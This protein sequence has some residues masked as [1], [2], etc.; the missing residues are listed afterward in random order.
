NSIISAELTRVF[1]NII[2][3]N[4]AVANQQLTGLES[5]RPVVY[6]LS[7]SGGELQFF[8]GGYL[9]NAGVQVQMSSNFASGSWQTVTNFPPTTNQPQFGIPIVP[10]A[11]STFFRANNGP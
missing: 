2:S 1:S 3:G 11:I 7:S 6:N 10:Q 5:N 4:L 8:I 9:S